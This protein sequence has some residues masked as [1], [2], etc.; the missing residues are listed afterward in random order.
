MHFLPFS[1]FWYDWSITKCGVGRFS[2][3][4]FLRVWLVDYQVVP[5]M[6]LHIFAIACIHVRRC[7]HAERMAGGATHLYQI[8]LIFCLRSSNYIQYFTIFYMY[9]EY[10]HFFFLRGV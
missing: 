4:F 6:G 3:F 5:E 2:P 7:V 1:F 8:L 10:Q 9:T